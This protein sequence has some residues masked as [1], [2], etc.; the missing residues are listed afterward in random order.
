MQPNKLQFK[1]VRGLDTT[2]WYSLKKRLTQKRCICCTN[3]IVLILVLFLIV[4]FPHF[5]VHTMATL[6]INIK[7]I[8]LAFLG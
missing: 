4:A 1:N 5:L 7:F 8:P 6:L 3:C 2:P